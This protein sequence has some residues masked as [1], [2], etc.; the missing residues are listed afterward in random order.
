MRRLGLGGT[1]TGFGGSVRSYSTPT[2]S[3]IRPNTGKETA[4]AAQA[5]VGRYGEELMFFAQRGYG[6]GG[7]VWV[8]RRRGINTVL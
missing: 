2:G 8:G 1:Y 6:D 4:A 5:E 7:R 3:K